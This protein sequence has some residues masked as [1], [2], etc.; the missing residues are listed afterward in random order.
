[1]ARGRKQPSPEQIVSLLGQIEVAVASGKTTPT[2]CR[3]VGI[4]EQTY[5]R[6]R[7]EYGG[8]ARIGWSE[9]GAAKG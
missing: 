9:S 1:M 4:T 2:A 5:C 6:W 8:L 7:K 3:E